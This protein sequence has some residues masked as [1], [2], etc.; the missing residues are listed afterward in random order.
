MQGAEHWVVAGLPGLE[1]IEP[2]L[3]GDRQTGCRV[4]KITQ[5]RVQ[6]VDQGQFVVSCPAWRGAGIVCVDLLRAG[7]A[8]F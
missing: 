8:E 7:V 3:G 4:A 6:V 2:W 1:L 5:D